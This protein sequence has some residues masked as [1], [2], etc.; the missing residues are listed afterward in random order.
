MVPDGQAFTDW[1]YDRY[2][3]D[4][5]N[6]FRELGDYRVPDNDATLATMRRV[7]DERFAEWTAAGRPAPMKVEPTFDP[8]IFEGA[9]IGLP[10]RESWQHFHPDVRAELEHQLATGEAFGLPAFEMPPPPKRRL[11]HAAPD[12]ER[13]IPEGFETVGSVPVS[14]SGAPMIK[15]AIKRLGVAPDDVHVATGSRSLSPRAGTLELMLIGAPSLGRARLEDEFR[16]A[17]TPPRIARAREA[18]RTVG[19]HAVHWQDFDV[20]VSA[21]W[22]RDGLVMHA[23]APDGAQLESLISLLP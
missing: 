2:L 13:L 16:A 10:P 14:R 23:S 19:G 8:A 11:S 12:L 9:T 6:A 17:F 4:Y 18:D 7:L 5:S 15:R 21:W 1:Y 3:E 22:C 20:F